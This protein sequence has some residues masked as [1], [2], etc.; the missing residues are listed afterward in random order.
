[1]GIFISNLTYSIIPI[2]INVNY[3]KKIRSFKINHA[4]PNSL[5]ILDNVFSPC[6]NSNSMRPRIFSSVN[7]ITIIRIKNSLYPIK[8]INAMNVFSE[9]IFKL[10]HAHTHHTFFLTT[11]HQF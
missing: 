8:I 2:L 6:V 7:D 4:F 9:N 1:M 3:K 10:R 11:I 5:V